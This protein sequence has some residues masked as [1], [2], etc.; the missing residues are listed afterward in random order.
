MSEAESA[1]ILDRLYWHETRPEFCCRHRWQAGDLVIWDNRS[2]LHFAVNDYDG[3][4]RLLYRS[5]FSDDHPP[6]G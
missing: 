5:T 2:T 6:R 3:H 1:P 4:D